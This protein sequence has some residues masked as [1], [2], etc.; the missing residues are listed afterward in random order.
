MFRVLV[1]VLCSLVE[2]ATRSTRS[3]EV[4]VVPRE[5]VGRSIRAVEAELEL[6][7]EV[8]VGAAVASRAC[9]AA[10]SSCAAICSA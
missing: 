2:G 5:V 7:V 3:G 9:L 1:D 10:I 4:A 8:P 6:L